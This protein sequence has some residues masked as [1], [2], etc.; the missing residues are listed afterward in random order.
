MNADDA[1]LFQTE[2]FIKW[3][4]HNERDRLYQ[5]EN[6]GIEIKREIDGNN[7][8]DAKGA[9]VEDWGVDYTNSRKCELQL[10]RYKQK[11]S[12]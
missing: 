12:F 3:L 11:C 1:V 6:Q 7:F 2:W 9:F 5:T 10:S 4:K 8:F